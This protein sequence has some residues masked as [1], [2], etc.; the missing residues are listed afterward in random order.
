MCALRRM[1]VPAGQ[2]VAAL[3]P[4][5]ESDRSPEQSDDAA[6]ARAK[7]PRFTAE[8]AESAESEQR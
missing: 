3:R 1:F 6:F 5:I 2:S 8:I 4:F 7:I